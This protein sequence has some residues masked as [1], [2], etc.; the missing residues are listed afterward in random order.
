[1]SHIEVRDRFC[2]FI[3]SENLCLVEI[4]NLVTFNE[5]NDRFAFKLAVV[6]F[7]FCL[8]SV[9]FLFILPCR[10]NHFPLLIV[11]QFY[12]VL[13]CNFLVSILVI[14][15]DSLSF[16]QMVGALNPL[17]DFPFTPCAGR[18]C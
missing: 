11:L 8:S 9:F 15:T 2:I 17:H 7:A 14:V 18:Q 12:C 4:P 10:I 5:I 6:L 1:M 16:F 3:K 13:L